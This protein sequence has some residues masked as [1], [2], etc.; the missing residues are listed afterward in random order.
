LEPA[1]D[2]LKDA[3]NLVDGI[4]VLTVKISGHFYLGKGYP[5]NYNPA[6]GRG[7]VAR[8]FRYDKIKI[9]R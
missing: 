4:D 7:G 6:K 3:D 9:V 5:E 8:V 1:N 2:K